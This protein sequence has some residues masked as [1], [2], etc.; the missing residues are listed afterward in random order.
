MIEQKTEQT[1]VEQIIMRRQIKFVG[2]NIHADADNHTY[3]RLYQE[4]SW[5]DFIDL[6]TIYN[7]KELILAGY[8]VV[9]I[10]QSWA[11]SKDLVSFGYEIAILEREIKI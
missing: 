9:S 11:A 7:L 6:R 4:S 8:K 1:K 2:T 10:T 3:N 5:R